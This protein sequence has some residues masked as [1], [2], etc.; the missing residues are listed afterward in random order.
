MLWARLKNS[1]QDGENQLCIRPIRPAYMTA[2]TTHAR[3]K[4]KMAMRLEH[5]ILKE[6]LYR[7]DTVVIFTST[8]KNAQ[9]GGK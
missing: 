1:L 8:I 3:K 2:K 9:V 7:E 4:V 6:T 5:R